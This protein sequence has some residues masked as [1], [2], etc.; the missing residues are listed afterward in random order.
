MGWCVVVGCSNNTFTKNRETNISFFRFPSNITLKK[1]WLANIK[2]E[3]PPKEAKICHQHFENSCFTRDLQNELLNKPLRRLLKDDAVPTLFP[4]NSGKQPQKRRSSILREETAVKQKLCEDA[5][6]HNEEVEHLELEMN[7]KGTQAVFTPETNCV[8]TQTEKQSNANKVNVAVQC[9][10]KP[11]QVAANNDLGEITC[12]SDSE[13]SYTETDCEYLNESEYSSDHEYNINTQVPQKAAFIVYWSSLLVFFQRCLTCSMPAFVKC[14]ST[15]GSQLMVKLLCVNNHN[16]TWR[17][18]PI[19][20]RYSQ[21]NLTQAAA[22]LFSA[23]TFKRMA[24]YFNLASI[25]WITK[26]SYYT[27]Q[28][29]F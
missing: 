11:I 20:N 13:S 26:T 10:Y 15:K 18:Q 1:K 28:R 12:S 25:Q 17:S 29:K 27:I 7:S 4:H 8:S 21:G 16:N 5:I 23:N 9:D 14:F 2:R 6:I 24:K 19:I 3:N 22:V